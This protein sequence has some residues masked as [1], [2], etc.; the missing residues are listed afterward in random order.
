MQQTI[1]QVEDFSIVKHNDKKWMKL[2]TN[3]QR[4]SKCTAI[5]GETYSEIPNET[6]V[7]VVATPE[8]LAKQYLI[9]NK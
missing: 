5:V 4:S 8:E 2:K 3:N 7:E 1:S 9:F 6:F